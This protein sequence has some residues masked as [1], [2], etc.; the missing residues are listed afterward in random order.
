M[1]EIL[2]T[3]K[4]TNQIYEDMKSVK[5]VFFD[6]NFDDK[7]I[8]PD[9]I[10]EIEFN[11][12]SQY[13]QKIENIN[14]VKKIYFAY[15]YNQLLDTLPENLEEIRIP[16]HYKHSMLCFPKNLKTVFIPLKL[17]NKIWANHFHQFEQIYNGKYE[18][19]H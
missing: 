4:I 11:I 5:K 14:N 16:Y 6:I 10:E 15:F 3:D 12:N 19:Y 18:Y 2:I 8:I 1:N 13:N 9:N 7:I 17:P